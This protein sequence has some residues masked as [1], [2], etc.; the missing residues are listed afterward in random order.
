MELENEATVESMYFSDFLNEDGD[1]NGSQTET[2]QE[3]QKSS[4]SGEGT[5]EVSRPEGAEE[6]GTESGQ[7]AQK[8]KEGSDDGD[9]EQTFTL[10]VNKEERTVSR[11]EMV[12]LAQKG[13]DYDR[14]KG[15]LESARETLQQLQE[16]ADSR[17]DLYELLELVSEQTGSQPEVLVEQLYINLCK[18][19][20]S[21][22][23]EAK[24]T[25]KAA[26]LEKQIKQ[27]ASNA[28]RAQTE[29]AEFRRQFPDV[30]ITEDLVNKLMEDVQS[31]MT[32]ANAYR[33]LVT[34]QQAA[35][36]AEL[37][38]QLAAEKQNSK[39]RASTPGSQQDSGGRQKK[40]SFDDFLGAFI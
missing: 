7:E 11:E 40:D 16:Q 8:A 12:E 37:Q 31:G 1:G 9:S 34:S 19:K 39:N 35:Q 25:L 22:E 26:R 14:V 33:K 20:G 13:A 23:G 29:V 36:I 17:K 24:A 4:E 21:T 15:Q 18:A 10:K 38:R 32:M 5:E 3:A 6:N 30:P 27:Q 28:K 2:S